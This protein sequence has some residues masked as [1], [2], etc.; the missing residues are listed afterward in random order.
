MIE[1]VNAAIVTRYV[2]MYLYLRHES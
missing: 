2:S 1:S